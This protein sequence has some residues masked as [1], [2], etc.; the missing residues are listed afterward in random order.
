ML[1]KTSLIHYLGRP[2]KASFGGFPIDATIGDRH[3]VF[4]LI[5][6]TGKGLASSIQVTLDHYGM[7]AIGSL[8][9]LREDVIEDRGLT[10]RILPTVGVA[11]VDHDGYR[12]VRLLKSFPGGGN[13]F[14]SVIRTGGTTAQDKLTVRVSS[15]R[16]GG[17]PSILGDTKKGL[18]HGGGHNPLTAAPKPRRLHS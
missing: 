8:L 15:G 16:D 3:S 2:T 4:K 10:G 9:D 1:R 6:R 17:C 14:G 5:E 18:T 13:V 11:A 7:N 12:G